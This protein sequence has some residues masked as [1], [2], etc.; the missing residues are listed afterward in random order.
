[1]RPLHLRE[2][3]V[4]HALWKV[5]QGT[6]PEILRTLAEEIPADR[7]S[8][9]ATLDDFVAAGYARAESRKVTD[10][11]GRR[12]EVVVYA[13]VVDVEEALRILWPQLREVVLDRDRFLDSFRRLVA[14]KS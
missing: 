12:A 2:W 5:G 3:P 7:H 4:F 10:D 8:V 6:A 11:E 13:P 14:E 9:R 1:M